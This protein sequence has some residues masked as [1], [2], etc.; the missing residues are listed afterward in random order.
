M[1]PHLF[2]IYTFCCSRGAGGMGFFF[3][4]LEDISVFVILTFFINTILLF[5]LV[6]FMNDKNHINLKHYHVHFSCI[7]VGI[8]LKYKFKYDKKYYYKN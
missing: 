1:G 5:P 8:F 3:I 6:K 2:C 4:Y 7:N